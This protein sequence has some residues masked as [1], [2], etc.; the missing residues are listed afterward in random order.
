LLHKIRGS[1]ARSQTNARLENHPEPQ[2]RLGPILDRRR[3][4][5]RNAQKHEAPPKN[6]PL[7]RHVQHQQEELL[8]LKPH[9]NEENIP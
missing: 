5:R 1:R 9:K 3:R 8:S 2:K 7:P 4:E 6:Q